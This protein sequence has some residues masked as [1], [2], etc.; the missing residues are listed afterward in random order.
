LLKSVFPFASDYFHVDNKQGATTHGTIMDV[1]SRTQKLFIVGV[2]MLIEAID[3]LN[4]IEVPIRKVRLNNKILHSLK[5][6]YFINLLN[7]FIWIIKARKI[8]TKI[9][10]EDS[11]DVLISTYGPRSPHLLASSIKQKLDIFWVADYRDLWTE[12]PYYKKNQIRFTIDKFLE[13]KSVINANI[14]TSVSSGMSDILSN[15]FNKQVFTIHN[16][17]ED[18]KIDK[19][20]INELSS[21]SLNKKKKF[22]YAGSIYPGKRDAKIL[23]QALKLLSSKGYAIEELVEVTFYG[24]ALGNTH[25]LIDKYQLSKVVK[26]PGSISRV[27]SLLVQS[28]ADALIYL[29]W[30]DVRNKDVIPA[31]IFEHINTNKPILGIG[32]SQYSE[33]GKIMTRSGNGYIL[34][35]S[36][37]KTADVIESI[38]L[39]NF[40]EP[41]V[42]KN[43]VAQFSREKL[44]K[45]MFKLIEESYVRFKNC[46][47]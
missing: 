9:N 20:G 13:N 36:I 33:A 23:F 40:N 38:F 44:A 37:E 6:L 30:F 29:D 46:E 3:K 15:K 11:F 25:E 47:K 41:K 5:I 28:S 43:F 45:K 34:E 12:N 14:I 18:L 8:V 22:I 42:D 7:S 2:K 16:G 26:T 21:E 19:A 4:L 10:K 27:K 35:N 17:F 32:V 24:D 31:K 39:G 1:D